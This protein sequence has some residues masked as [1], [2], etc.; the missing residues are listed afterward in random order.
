MA[1]DGEGITEARGG[2]EEVDEEGRGGGVAE[3]GAAEDL[4]VDLLELC[5]GGG[6][7]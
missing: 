3:V 5:R 6:G 7:G 4:G 1:E 2:E